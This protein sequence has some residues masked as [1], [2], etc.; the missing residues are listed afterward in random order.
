VGGGEAKRYENRR[1]LGPVSGE[2]HARTL[3]CVDCHNRATHIYEEPDSGLDARFAAGELDPD[4]PFL[5]REALGAILSGWSSPAAARAGVENHVRGF[6]RESY[7]GLAVA[8]MESIDRAV[9]SIQG[10]VARNLH[11]GMKI[12]WNAYPSHLGHRAGGGCFRCHNEAMVDS[13]G[14]AI[15]YDCTLC[16]SIL[17]QESSEPFR[18][19]MPLDDKDPEREQAG[20]LRREFLAS[21]GV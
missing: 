2:E 16:H 11:P 19:L 8:K 18:F 7:P 21:G 6:Y 17:A 14:T 10:M 20:Y 9:A 12:G 5:K 13:E 4:L 3:D 15:S 1:R